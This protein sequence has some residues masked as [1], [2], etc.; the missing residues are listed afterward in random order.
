MKWRGFSLKTILVTGGAGFIGS[1]FVRYL[2]DKYPDYR[3]MVVDAL[4][5]AGNIENCP[6][7][8][9]ESDRYQFWYGDVRNAELIDTLVAQ[10]D[11]VLHMA[12]ESHVTR[13]IYDNKLFFETDVLGTQV[14]ANAVLKHRSTVERFI[15]ISTSEVYGTALSQK[16]P[17]EHPLNPMSPYASA[18]CG[19]DR[20]VYSYWATYQIPAIIVRPFNNFGPR[21]HLE[22]V[23]PR[24]VTSCLLHEP[25]TVHG[26]GSA[27]RDFMFVEDHCDALDLLMQV[28]LERV[29]GQVINL[30]AGQHYSILDIANT[31][32]DLMQPEDSPIMLIGDR[33]GQVFRHTCDAS[34][35]ERLLGWKARTSLEE[36]LE[37]TIRWYRKNEAWWRPQMW[38]RHIPI[39]T[40]G[41]KREMH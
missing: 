4:T 2:F 36:G 31:V 12:A 22:K 5:Y 24:F 19:A 28:D 41:G 39:L 40:A 10:S 23:V 3:L 9:M 34:K 14:V 16:M 20:L 17:E 32:R 8:A 29:V 15:H 21:Q 33:P 37:R 27:A 25:L 11:V 18:K 7:G 6:D 1:N 30:G 26:D 38:M 35:A 13:S